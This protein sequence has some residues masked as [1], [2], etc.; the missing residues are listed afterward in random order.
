MPDASDHA[1]REPPEPVVNRFGHR[2]EAHRPAPE[3]CRL[4]RAR[5]RID[6]LGV[7]VVAAFGAGREDRGAVHPPEHRASEEEEDRQLVPRVVVEVA[8]QDA[9]VLRPLEIGVESQCRRVGPRAD[10]DRVDHPDRGGQEDGRNEGEE[11]VRPPLVPA[12]PF[13]QTERPG[14]DRAA[15]QEQDDLPVAALAQGTGHAQSVGRREFQVGEVLDHQPEIVSD[16]IHVRQ[17][18]DAHA[19]GKEH[20]RENAQNPSQIVPNWE[21]T[22]RALRMAKRVGCPRRIPSGST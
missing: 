15:P 18:H 6:D 10:Q 4:V 7:F 1:D 17:E 19:G 3:E 9:E 13:E 2:V 21:S 8:P 11:Q 14:G 12:Q 22:M 5:G 16:L 20:D